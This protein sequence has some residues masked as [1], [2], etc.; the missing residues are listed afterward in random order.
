CVGHRYE[1]LALV[2]AMLATGITPDFIVIDGSEGGTGA[3]P[4]EL[5]NHVGVPL[6]EGLSFVHNALV[7]AALRDKIKL[8][9]SGK[10]ITAFDICR[11]GALGADYVL[12]ARGFMFAIG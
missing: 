7:G 1:F 4:L 8:G 5:V 11:A 12:S 2:K 10:I 9:A 3:A 6:A